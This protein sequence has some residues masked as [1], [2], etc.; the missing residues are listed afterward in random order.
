[1]SEQEIHWAPRVPQELIRHLYEN[2]ALGFTDRELL[3]EVGWRL[4]ARCRSFI[5]AVESVSGKVS[6]PVCAQLI[7]HTGNREEVLHC[8]ACGWEMTWME[9]FSFIQH[10]QLSGAEP[11]VRLFQEF[12]RRFP[13][14]DHYSEKML[15]VDQ[16]I[17]GFH[18]YFKDAS[19]TRTTAVNLI[20]GRYHDVVDFLDR[21]S[22]GPQSTPG[23]LVTYLKWR[24]TIDETGRKWG[25]EKLRRR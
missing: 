23:T 22:Y 18:I 14:A 3:D 16:L 9:Y 8:S 13:L 17:H 19:Q 24:Q 7:L 12:I 20:E 4:L 2:D 15:L 25:D 6:C 21:L 11:V 10:Q 5:Q 1:M